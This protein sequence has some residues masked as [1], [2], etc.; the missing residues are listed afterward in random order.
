MSSAEPMIRQ[1]MVESIGRQL[2]ACMLDTTAAASVRPAGLRAGPN[3]LSTPTPASAGVDAM[4]T[5]LGA[6]AG[7]VAGVGGLDLAFVADAASAVKMN[8]NVGPRFNFPILPSKALADKTVICIS[9]LALRVV[10][11]P[12]RRIAAANSA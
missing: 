7:A 6:L 8:F 12:S 5:D 1:I 2:D 4:M 3:A 10:V 9:L 11:N